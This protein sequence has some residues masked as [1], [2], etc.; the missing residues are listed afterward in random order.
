MR[1]QNTRGRYRKISPLFRTGNGNFSNFTNMFYTYNDRRKEGARR[2]PRMLFAM[3]L[4][5]LIPTTVL[6]AQ[7]INRSNYELLWRIDGPGMTSPSYLFGTMH[8][9]DKRVFEFSDSVLLAL[10]NAGK[11]QAT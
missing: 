8:L 1:A 5:L 11:R 10:R 6:R 3:L 7:R 9:T 2:F 4:I